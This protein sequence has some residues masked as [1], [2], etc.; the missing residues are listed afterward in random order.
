[1]EGIELVTEG[2]ITL[3]RCL[4]VLEEDANIESLPDDAVKKLVKILI[5]S[6]IINCVV[7]TKI[8]DA[9]QDPALPKDLEIRRNLMKQFCLILERKYYKATTLVLV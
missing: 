2:T 4:R 7:G 6:D 1:M 5:D 3:S 8:N 9:H